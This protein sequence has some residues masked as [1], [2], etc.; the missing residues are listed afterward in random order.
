MFASRELS[1]LDPLWG[2]Q[3]DRAA[4]ALVARVDAGGSDWI[5]WFRPETR[6]VV[7]WGGRPDGKQ[8][9]PTAGGGMQLNPRASF[10]EY[11]E[12]VT[13]TCDRWSPEQI[14]AAG[15][16]ARRLA[17][18]KANRA[19]RRAEFAAALQ[20]AVM[21]DGFPAV[22]G[23]D[24]A[25]QYRPAAGDPIGG[26]WYDVFFQ[27]DGTPIVAL[28]DVAGHGVEAAATMSQ[29]RHTLRAYLV[30]DRDPAEA[31]ARLN[32]VM[33]TLL[34]GEMATALLVELDIGGRRAH[35]INAGHLPPIVVDANGGRLVEP[36]N[37]KLLGIHPTASYRTFS[38]DLP[39]GSALI[40]YSDGLVERRAQTLDQCLF[41]LVD[42]AGHL[43]A[44]SAEE[45]CDGLIHGVGALADTKDDVT[46]LALRFT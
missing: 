43:A 31:M 23:V 3:G 28:G 45:I 13:G 7:R 18:L 26:D 20:Q 39:P 38:I 36:H 6:R 15:T 19:H 33:R 9:R 32:D 10:D 8:A 27:A 37:D 44:R 30:R 24:G 22:P 5:I 35:V 46:V 25:A 29:L 17:E 11:L 12:V 2:E 34:P 42:A 14:N 41:E 4:G 40:L 21:I 16:L 1:A